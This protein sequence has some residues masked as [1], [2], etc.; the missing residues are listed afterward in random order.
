MAC[1]A[2]ALLRRAAIVLA[3]T[4]G[5]A[6]AAQRIGAAPYTET[7]D[8]GFKACCIG[9]LR[10]RAAEAEGTHKPQTCR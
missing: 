5:R 6:G 1:R 4:G 8:S 3:R 10:G 7:P 2:C 9:V